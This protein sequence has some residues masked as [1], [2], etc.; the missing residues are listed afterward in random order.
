LR[1][2]S[3]LDDS[4]LHDLGIGRGELE[5]VVRHGRERE[6]VVQGFELNRPDRGPTRVSSWTE[7]R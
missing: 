3:S 2:V 6:N 4:M 5:N 7:L 1:D